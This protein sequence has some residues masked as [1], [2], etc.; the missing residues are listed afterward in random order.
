MG[1]FSRLKK[2]K[3]ND[4]KDP[5]YVA[6]PNFYE[7]EEGNPFGAFALTENS[8]T[9]LPKAPQKRYQVDGKQVTDWKL[10]LVSTTKDTAIG[11]C[12]YFQ[13]LEKLESYILE[14]HDDTILVKGL[15]LNELESLMQ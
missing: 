11:Y 15:S 10:V 2:G 8:E 5:A 7:D 1:L 12:D 9:I 6:R 4:E 3:T 13:T 14:V